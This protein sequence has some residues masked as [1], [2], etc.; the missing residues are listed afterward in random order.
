MTENHEFREFTN[1]VGSST[2]LRSLESVIH[3]G[4]SVARQCQRMLKIRRSEDGEIAVFALSGRIEEQHVSEL[5][6]LLAGEAEVSK[7]ALDLEEVRLVDREVVRFLA[8]CE[9][10]G[11]R[12]RNCPSY[13]RE[14]IETGRE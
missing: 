6:E 2:S 4:I 14:W 3:D 9:G 12:L 10:R 7:I 13:V 5:Q 1:F 11:V 8:A